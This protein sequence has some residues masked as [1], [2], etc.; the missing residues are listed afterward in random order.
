LI[1]AG[2]AGAALS[3]AFGRFAILL[4][5]RRRAV[6]GWR[7]IRGHIREDCIRFACDISAQSIIVAQRL[8]IERSELLQHVC[9]QRR[10]IVIVCQ[11]QTIQHVTRFAQIAD[12]R[13]SKNCFR[14]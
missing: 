8:R 5:L 10:E 7:E 6:I 2:A 4:I 11:V 12:Q 1:S 9:A 14:I 13:V 3:F